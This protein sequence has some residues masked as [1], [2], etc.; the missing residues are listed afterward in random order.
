M[1][2]LLIDYPS[3][4]DSAYIDIILFSTR[5]NPTAISVIAL[6]F[7]EVDFDRD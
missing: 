1:V 7:C 2:L 3:L 4:M 6:I 5:L